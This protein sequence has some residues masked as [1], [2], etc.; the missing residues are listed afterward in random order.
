MFTPD[1]VQGLANAIEEILRMN[2]EHNELMR[3]KYMMAISTVNMMKT[4]RE[5]EAKAKA[6]ADAKAK[7]VE[8]SLRKAAKEAPAELVK[9]TPSEQEHPSSN[10]DSPVE[11]PIDTKTTTKK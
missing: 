9:D 2:T 1:E 5:E 11:I 7:A 4:K 6:V 8:D 3:M 10:N